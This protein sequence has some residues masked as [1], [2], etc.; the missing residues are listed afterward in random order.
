MKKPANGLSSKMSSFM[1]RQQASYIFG[2]KNGCSGNGYILM[3]NSREAAFFALLHSLKGES[4]IS[5]YLG[6]WFKKEQPSSQDYQLAHQIAYG[7]AQM[8]LALDYLALQLSEK[9]KMRLKLKEKA[10]LRTAL[11]QFYFLDKLPHYAIADESIKI[12][13]K[14]FH[15]YFVAYLN[16]IL[17]KFPLLSLSLPQGMDL[18]S[19]SIR[20]SF[21]LYFIKALNKHYGLQTTIKILE[22]SNKPV[23]T[24]ARLRNIVETPAEWN[25][26]IE[27]PVK[28][29]TVPASEV[30]WVASSA[31][32]YIQ[33]VTPASLIANLSQGISKTPTSILDVCASPGG[34]TLALHD[35]F[36]QAALYANDVSLQKIQKLKDNFAKYGVQAQVSCSEGEKLE[37]DKKFDLIV[38]DV[39]CSNSGV[40][41]KR[42]EARWRLH[43]DQAKQLKIIQFNLLKHAAHLLENE[44]EIWYMTCSILPEENEEIVAIACQELGLMK[45]NLISILPNAE[46]WDGGFACCLVK[47]LR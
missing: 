42:P 9:K 39:P 30:K 6:E 45:K 35:F 21:P 34:K 37:L 1:P 10:L 28:I 13:K 41:S 3:I 38:L 47:K 43:E 14:H 29:I 24:M 27:K 22:A 17:R 25:T 36:P 5:E 33:N 7:S 4:F 12:A 32:Y 46:G 15:S 16:A 19:L 20:Y 23:L 31:N 8:A 26:V 40:L 18:S 44:G 2:F 11:Y